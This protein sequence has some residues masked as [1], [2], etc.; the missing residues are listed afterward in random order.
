MAAYLRALKSVP[1][2]KAEAFAE[3]AVQRYANR[4]GPTAALRVPAT[5]RGYLM[6]RPEH[7]G[8]VEI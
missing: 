7:E 2:S 4:W 3:D 8:L 5:L 6:V 1:P